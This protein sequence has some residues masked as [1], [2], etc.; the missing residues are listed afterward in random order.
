MIDV[1]QENIG[2]KYGRKIENKDEQLGSIMATNEVSDASKGW[3]EIS[4]KRVI[5][6]ITMEQMDIIALSSRAFVSE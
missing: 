3:Y 2:T 6:E 4:D 1:E 5:S